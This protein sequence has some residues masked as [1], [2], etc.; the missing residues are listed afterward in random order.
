MGQGGLYIL[1]STEVTHLFVQGVVLLYQ[2]MH[3][4]ITMLFVACQIV[5]IKSN[6][7]L[8]FCFS[9]FV[10]SFLLYFFV[11]LL[12][13]NEAFYIFFCSEDAVNID[14][15]RISFCNFGN[16]LKKG[17]DVNGFVIS[18]FC[19]SLFHKNHPSKSKKNYFFPSIGDMLISHLNSK[20]LAKIEKS[21]QGAAMVRILHK[22]DLVII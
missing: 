19:Q 3:T 6:L 4:D 1:P 13:L 16:S 7:I 9:Q 5:N 2:T 20:E 18:A 10:C 14:N 15:V 17:G 21:F 8:F 22:C 11:V 12:S